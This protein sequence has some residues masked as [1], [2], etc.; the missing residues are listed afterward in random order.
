M[1]KLVMTSTTYFSPNYPPEP[2]LD[3]YDAP[4]SQNGRDKIYFS[5]CPKSVAGQLLTVRLHS[6]EDGL[7]N[8]VGLVPVRCVSYCRDRWYP[9]ITDRTFLGPVATVRD[10]SDRDETYL[11]LKPVF[12]R[13][14][15]NRQ[16]LSSDRFGRF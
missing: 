14:L 10:A 1:I 13:M 3:L 7:Q 4:F 5:K 11:I 2:S 8:E 9:S 6:L 12:S 16:K 15:S